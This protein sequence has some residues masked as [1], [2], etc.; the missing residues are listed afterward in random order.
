MLFSI[1]VI[2]LCSSQRASKPL[3]QS[4]INSPGARASGS[5][6][7]VKDYKPAFWIR[8]LIRAAQTDNQKHCSGHLSGHSKQERMP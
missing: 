7:T 1:L 5:H 4:F 8:A 6:L 3:P 2:F